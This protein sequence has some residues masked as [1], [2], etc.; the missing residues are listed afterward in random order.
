MVA[1]DFRQRI[2]ESRAIVKGGRPLVVRYPCLMGHLAVFAV[3]LRERLDV[4]TGECYGDDEHI[5]LTPCAETPNHFH[6]PGAQPAHRAYVRLIREQVRIGDR[7]PLH[8]PLYAGP[9]L[10]GIR[11]PPIDHIQRQ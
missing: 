6:R 8:H 1:D 2:Q 10:L 3:E 11:I 4:V 5:L 7:Q 9:H